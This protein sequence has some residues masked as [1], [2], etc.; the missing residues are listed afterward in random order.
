M[1]VTLLSRYA[2]DPSR[3][4]LAQAGGDLARRTLLPAVALWAAIVAIGLVIVGPLRSLPAELAVNRALE[5]GR[6][7]AWNT[8]TA[9]WT[10]I[11][12]TVFIIS[13]ALIMVAVLWWRTKQWWLAVVPLIAVSVQSAVFVTAAAVVGRGRP[14]VEHLDVAPPTSSF[15]SGHVGASTALYLTLAMLSQR[16]SSPV[17][18]WVATLVCLAVPVFVAYSRLYRGMHH[19]SDVLVGALNG[20]VCAWLAWRY[21]RRTEQP[22]TRA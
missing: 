16:I 6:T 22:Q 5:A 4:T 12:G 15:P 13:A 14:E 11:G 3:P 10:H 9:V 21:L 18:R 20:V 7:P 1:T 2:D 8:V 19:L 17:L